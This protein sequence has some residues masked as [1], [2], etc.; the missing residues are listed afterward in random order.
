MERSK[1]VQ[2][3]NRAGVQTIGIVGYTN[4]GK[5]ALMNAMTGAQLKSRDLPF[6][7]LDTTMRKVHLP[8]GGHAILSDSIGFIQQLPHFLFAAFKLTMEELVNCD[9][10]L[11]VRDMS[12]P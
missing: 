9:V 1:E 6:Q 8:S 5:T 3:L 2:R 7:T 10:L 11:H 12:H 4:V